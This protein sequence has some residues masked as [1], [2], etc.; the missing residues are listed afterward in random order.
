MAGCKHTGHGGQTEAFNKGEETDAV[1]YICDALF[2]YSFE[3]LGCAGRLVITP[4][5]D[6]IYI[7]ATQSAHLILGCAPQGPAGTGKTESVKDLSAQLGKAVYVFNCGPEMDY[8]TL[9]DIF[10][11]LA[12]SG[13][14]GCFD[15]FNRLVAEVLSVT[16]IQWKSVLD[17]IRAGGSS[18]RF[19][20]LDCFLDRDGCMSFITMN[21]G[22]LGR[23]ELPESLKVLFRPVTVMVP[24][25]QLI[26]ENMMMAE[27]YTTAAELAKKFFTL[28][29]LSGD[30]LGGNPSPPGKQLHYDWG[31]RAINSVLQVAGSFLRGEKVQLL[32]SGMANET[33]EA[34]LLMR[35]LRDFNLPKI[36]DDDMIVFM[37]LIKD[38]FADC[39]DLMPRMR[40]YDFEG[41][42]KTVAQEADA[43][44]FPPKLQATDYFVQNV[45]DLQDLLALRHCVFLIGLS[46]SNKSETW[47]TLA[48]CWTKGG[49]MGKTT[50]KD[51]NPKS[52]TPN[53]LYGYINM[54]T[55]EWKDGLLSSSMRDLANAPDSNPKWIVLD[56]DL[57]ANWIENMNSVM[58]D[59]RLLTLA[60]NERIRLLQNMKMMFEIRDLVFASPATVTRAGVLFISDDRQYKNYVASWLDGWIEELP[61]VVK[62]DARVLLKEKAEALFEKYIDPVLL[63]LSLNYKHVVPLLE[64]GLVQT[65]TSFLSG[66]WV[67][68]NIG[69][70]DAT[71]LEIY[72]VFA[73]VWGFG[74]AM[75]ITSGTD[76]RRKFS[77]YW[78]D[79][80]KAIKFPHRG[81]VFD[82]FVEKT[83]K[84][85]VSWQDIVPELEF[86]S[87]TTKMSDITVP[88]ME[89]VAISFWLDNLLTNKT[90]A[91]LIGAAGCGKTALIN[92]KLRALPEE[93][94]ST[95]VNI[96]YYT[97]SSMYQKVLEAPLEKKAGKNYGPPG[98][99]KLIYF[100]DDLNMAALDK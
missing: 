28:Y 1:L 91:M 81:E 54:A 11:G 15:E 78:K 75:S 48:K 57:D 18:F 67:V 44:R 8:R 72:F 10:K 5:T 47:K 65:I 53:E 86:D 62:A 26:M 20:G 90:G 35:A 100:V 49:V 14:W 7:T 37:G 41:L 34:G 73:C 19:N 99:K 3:Y 79:T 39:F 76:Y 12:S 43:T 30:L 63:E 80:W 46:G 92:G 96:N 40:D 42:V 71:N 13:S 74:G 27:G 93:Y 66:L 64:F 84:D 4:L 17:G 6:R 45:V 50:F 36:V 88:T 68:D 61:F 95:T 22:Y 89:T 33:V 29:Q 60:S 31:L 70:K 16:T 87:G 98:N 52:I 56:G 77:Q 21:P 32:A 94:S 38:L 55:R 9:G 69:T 58:D 85:F 83:K 59:N 97:N 82:V 51:I 25:F 24:D 2:R 23:Q